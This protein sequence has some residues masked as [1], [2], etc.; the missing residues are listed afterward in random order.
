MNYSVSIIIPLSLSIMYWERIN[1]E[2][3]ITLI[4]WRE[5]LFSAAMV[6]SERGQRLEAVGEGK[7][8]MS[9]FK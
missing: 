8:Q 6:Q 2:K 5:K 3:V 7:C 1:S 9:K 4:P